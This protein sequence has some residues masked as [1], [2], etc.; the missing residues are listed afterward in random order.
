MLEYQKIILK[1]VCF[2]RQLFEKELMK[3]LNWI[4]PTQKMEFEKWVETE[5]S[6][7]YPDILQNA[8]HIKAA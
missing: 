8:F 6:E 4:R 5:F 7:I 1:K 2:D 3:T